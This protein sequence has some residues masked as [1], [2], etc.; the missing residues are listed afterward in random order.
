M[1]RYY[2]W[3][4][5]CFFAICLLLSGCGISTLFNN[6]EE[7]EVNEMIAIL[8]QYGIAANKVI[9]KESCA[10]TVASNDFP[11][12]INLLELQGYPLPK[13][14]T[15]GDVFKKSGLVSSP[16]EE[17]IRFMNALSES[18]A[19]TISKIPGVLKSRVHIVLPENDPDAEHVTPSSAAVFITYRPDSS[20]EDWVREIKFLVTNSIE[21]LDFNKVSVA[22]FPVTLPPLPKVPKNTDAMFS[23]AGINMTDDTKMQFFMLIGAML[24]IIL[25]LTLSN[26]FVWLSARRRKKEKEVSVDNLAEASDTPHAPATA[27]N[28]H[29]EE[30]LD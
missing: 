30:S 3:W 26:I 13:Y 23:C 6:L 24:A 7:Q 9:G 16:L 20:V 29:K 21:G 1:E 14:Q 10:L 5:I 28:E 27:A 12:A 4:N 11:I 17:R 15:L 22:L 19:L 18:I 8:K 25:V 2:G